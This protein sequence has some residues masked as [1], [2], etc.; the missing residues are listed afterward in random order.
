MLARDCVQQLIVQGEMFGKRWGWR[1]F[2]GRN[3]HTSMKRDAG[4]SDPS[5]VMKNCLHR[6]H[7]R[8]RLLKTLFL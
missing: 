1:V 8:F 6:R 7:Y 4:G 3:R 2:E 5:S